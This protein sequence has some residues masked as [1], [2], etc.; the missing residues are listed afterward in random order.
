M[1]PPDKQN[2]GWSQWENHVLAELKRHNE[3]CNE[4]ADTQTTILVQ[5]SALKTEMKFR[6]GVWGLIAGAIPA[7]VGL[8]IWLMKST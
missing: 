8:V 4:L 1:T 6:A 7:T 2:N 5:I 3:W